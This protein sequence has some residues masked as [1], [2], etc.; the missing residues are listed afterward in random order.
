MRPLTSI[1]AVTDRVRNCSAAFGWSAVLNYSWHSSSLIT[2][3]LGFVFNI[4]WL[5]LLCT[6]EQWGHFPLTNS[7][8]YTKSMGEVKRRTIP[9]VGEN[10]EKPEPSYMASWNAIWCRCFGKWSGSSSKSYTLSYHNLTIPLQGLCSKE[11][12]TY[13]HSKTCSWM[14]SYIM[15]ISTSRNNSN[16]HELTNR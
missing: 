11:M 5:E 4:S 6:K 2:H 14:F 13:V 8:T 1:T 3:T 16:V 7:Q 9:S 15:Y 10:L 12:K